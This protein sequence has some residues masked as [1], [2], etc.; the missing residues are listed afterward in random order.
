MT[1]VKRREPSPC[2]RSGET[3]PFGHPDAI[4]LGLPA[5]QA[6][7]ALDRE[8]SPS[9]LS[10]PQAGS[11]EVG[12]IPF[13]LNLSCLYPLS[14]REETYLAAGHDSA[15]AAEFQS[16]DASPFALIVGVLCF[17]LAIVQILTL[18]VA[19]IRG[20]AGRCCPRSRSRYGSLAC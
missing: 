13:V 11:A 14:V 9:A 3:L 10:T 18:C 20:S 5:I 15:A 4:D 7:L 8:N 12:E 6:P 2:P 17:C 19:R 16:R 1:F